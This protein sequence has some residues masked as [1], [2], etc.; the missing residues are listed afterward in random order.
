MRSYLW[1]NL[2]CKII[3][4]L[5]DHI[6]SIKYVISFYYMQH[7]SIIYIVYSILAIVI[8]ILFIQ[9]TDLI[10]YVTLNVQNSNDDIGQI[11]K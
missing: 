9:H 6:W 3:M 7:R 8:A 4:V 5:D 1:E 2:L 10:E 11:S